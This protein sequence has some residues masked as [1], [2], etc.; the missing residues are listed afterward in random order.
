MS[1]RKIYWRKVSRSVPDDGITV[2]MCD[3]DGEVYPGFRLAGEWR[4]ITADLVKDTITHWADLPLPPQ[5]AR[6][7]RALRK[8]TL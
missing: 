2:L 7:A 3:L 4:Y 5:R 1:A 8:V 6:S